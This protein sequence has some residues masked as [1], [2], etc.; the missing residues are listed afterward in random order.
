MPSLA[1]GSRTPR[2][3]D[4]CRRL[5]RVFRNR[6]EAMRVPQHT[7]GL[8]RRLFHS[9]VSCIGLCRITSRHHRTSSTMVTRRTTASMG[10]H[11]ARTLRPTAGIARSI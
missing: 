1:G 8:L 9:R 5:G 2:G 11:G 4:R 10:P 6:G 3:T 7:A